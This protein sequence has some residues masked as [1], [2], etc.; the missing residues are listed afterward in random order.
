MNISIKN[1]AKKFGR[2]VFLQD[3]EGWNSEIFHCFIQPL[4]YKNKMYLNKVITEL[5]YSGTRKFLLICPPS[6]PIDKADGYSCHIYVKKDRFCV[7]HSEI[8]YA[9]EEEVYRWS[10]VHQVN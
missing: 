1:F 7:D 10:I 2:S 5:S 4:R 6:I 9:G 8:V 3:E